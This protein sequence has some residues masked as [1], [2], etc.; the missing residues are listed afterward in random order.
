MSKPDKVCPGCHIAQ[1]LEALTDL[2]TEL[3]LMCVAE[4]KR[5]R[6]EQHRG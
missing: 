6:W 5:Q 2:R 4:Y 3:C 1:P